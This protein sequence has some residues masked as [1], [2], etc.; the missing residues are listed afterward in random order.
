[1]ISDTD[2]PI[3][4]PEGQ[5]EFLPGVII[6]AFGKQ[7][8]A[9][10]EK[11]N[12]TCSVRVNV[13]RDSAVD[14]AVVVGDNA[15]LTQLSETEAVIERILPRQSAFFRP[16][17]GLAG[18][19]QT[20]AAN[21]EQL[22]IVSSCSE[23]ALKP[24]LID[25]F[26]IA[27][28]TGG[29]R[30]IVVINKADLGVSD[31]ARTLRAG[32][33]MIHIPAVIASAVTGEG[34]ERLKKLL[35]G[36]KSLFVGHSGVGKST[37]LNAL[38]PG[39]NLK[40]AELSEYSNRGRHTTTRVELHELPSGGFVLDSPGLKVLSLWKVEKKTLAQHFREFEQFAPH[41]RFGDCAH[42]AE[43]DCAVREAAEKGEIPYFRYESYT[44]IRET[45]Q[46]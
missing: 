43:P 7:F 30:P 34:L 13:K 44:H 5:D 18:R 16:E 21:I 20:L 32:Y 14:T 31:L 37:L 38:L 23:P 41:C 33:E 10:T 15:L 3:V 22:V 6:R 24:R 35:A 45:L 11:G 17:K 4:R 1:M 36:G 46:K 29:L 25:R 9:R 40:T 8:I 26:V 42:I 28:D 27:G 12:L 39:L 19:K 2:S